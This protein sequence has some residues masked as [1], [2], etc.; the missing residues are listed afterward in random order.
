MKFHLYR[1]TINSKHIYRF[2]NN[3]KEIKIRDITFNQNGNDSLASFTI[4]SS[5]YNTVTEIAKDN[6]IKIINVHEFGLY[7]KITH[8]FFIKLAATFAIFFILFIVISTQFIWKITINGNYS[9]TQKE[10][11]DYVSCLNVT[12]GVLKNKVNCENIEKNIRENYNDISWVCA[13]I[14][15]TNLIIHI[16]ENYITEIAKM[17]PS[18]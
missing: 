16:K 11:L 10:I 1:I 8:S 14:K 13:E 18:L 7:K 3:T 12:E 9:Y 17:K 5:D 4:N 6:N 2:L 15:G